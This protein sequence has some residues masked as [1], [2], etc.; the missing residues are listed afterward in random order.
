[1]SN[2]TTTTIITTNFSLPNDFGVSYYFLYAHPALYSIA[3]LFGLLSSIV[4][5]TKE[6]RTNS[7]FFQYS[8]VN[9][10]G[11]TIIAFLMIFLFLTNCH[12]LCSTST[13]YSAQLYIIYGFYLI[14]SGFYTASGF[15]QIAI[16][17]QMYFSIKN[18][19]PRLSKLNPYKV[20]LVLICKPFFL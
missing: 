7:P 4:L 19:N 6:L 9:S 20:S 12:S 10:I 11:M 2:L 17:F 1:M 3:T 8:L 16:G 18:I 13:T 15:I 14:I 5:S